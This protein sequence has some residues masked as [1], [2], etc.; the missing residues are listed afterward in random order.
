MKD[1]KDFETKGNVSWLAFMSLIC[2]ITLGYFM[3]EL[4]DK[5]AT[6]QRQ[7]RILEKKEL[8]K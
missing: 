6:L 4:F 2:F 3:G 1:E 8:H 7:V 5:V